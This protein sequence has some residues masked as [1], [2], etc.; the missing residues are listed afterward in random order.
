[1]TGEAII[2][3]IQPD[4]KVEINFEGLRAS[5]TRALGSLYTPSTILDLKADLGH[6]KFPATVSEKPQKAMLRQWVQEHIKCRGQSQES[7]G[8]RHPGVSTDRDMG[9][10]F[11]ISRCKYLHGLFSPHLR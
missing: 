7:H 6:D 9:F 3:V 1:M 10:R 5:V 8:M 2:A 11:W 4:Q